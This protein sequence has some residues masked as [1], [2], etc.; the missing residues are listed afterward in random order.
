[1]EQISLYFTEE[2]CNIFPIESSNYKLFNSS[3][4]VLSKSFQPS[5]LV[6]SPKK[7]VCINANS[8]N[9][10]SSMNKKSGKN[11]KEINYDFRPICRKL[12][13]SDNSDNNYNNS[14]S[15][16]SDNENIEINEDYSDFSNEAKNSDYSGSLEDGKH[17][18]RKSYK[19]K[20]DSY[21]KEFTFMKKKQSS[22]QI[23]Y[24][25]N[26]SKFDEEYV[27]IKTLCDG[28]MGTVYLC[29]RIKDKKKYVVKMSKYFSRKLDYD[30]MINFVNDINRNSSEPGIV[31]IQKYIDFWIEDIY[32]KNN[33]STANTKYMYI[34]TDYCIN[35]NLKE[36]LSKIKLNHNIKLNYSFYWDIIFQ[37]IIPIN[38]LHKL[39][40]IHF[41]IKLT[42]YLVT[43]NNLLLL[44]DFC[45]SIKEENI[46][47]ISTDE[48]EGDSI[49]ISPELFCKDVGIIT[50]KIDIYSLGL[51]ILELLTEIELPKNGVVWQKMRNHE[52]PK[53]FLEKIPLID[54][55]HENRNKLIELIVE[56]TNINSNLRPEL[57]ILFNDE[58]KF[59]ELYHRYQM[60]KNNSYL[61][62]VFI[63]AV[64]IN[65]LNEEIC[66]NNIEEEKLEKGN[67]NES[68]ENINSIFVKR[69][70]SMKCI[71]QNSSSETIF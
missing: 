21:I 38:F 59:P 53:E 4:K 46:G 36:Y 2:T 40:Y 30:N 9:E 64:N 14:N 51:S 1:M 26:K 67:I 5:K 31:F 13:F 16:I 28:E 8:T 44:N 33:K 66:K 7:E 55:D 34:V 27:I 11:K 56:M 3:S 43:N 23:S 42:N 17:K 71:S 41:D 50:H 58:N 20:K 60:L 69:S 61:E 12:D 29:F 65:I 10:K 15:S 48:L 49:Y 24:N 47:R 6:I 32:E 37:M 45:L 25:T 18:K 63:N 54:N 68:N 57:D 19:N 39:G 52:I 62:N 22:E 35:G 70:N